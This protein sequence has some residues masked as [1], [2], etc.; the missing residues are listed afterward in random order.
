MH[1]LNRI[2]DVSQILDSLFQTKTVDL[3]KV[4]EEGASVHVLHC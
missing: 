2:D 1:V 3:V 4:V